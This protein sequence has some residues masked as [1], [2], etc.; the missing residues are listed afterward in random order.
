MRGASSVN[1][2]DV[3]TPAQVHANPVRTRQVRDRALYC[4]IE[5][6]QPE[7]KAKVELQFVSSHLGNLSLDSPERGPSFAQRLYASALSSRSSTL[8]PSTIPV[9]PPT[10]H[11]SSALPSDPC[12]VSSRKVLPSAS[13]SDASPEV[14]QYSNPSGLYHRSIATHG[15]LPRGSPSAEAGATRHLPPLPKSGNLNSLSVTSLSYLA[16]SLES[17]SSQNSTLQPE[18]QSPRSVLHSLQTLSKTARS[19]STSAVDTRKVSGILGVTVEAHQDLH[20]TISSPSPWEQQSITSS[21]PPPPFSGHERLSSSFDE[22]HSRRPLPGVNHEEIPLYSLVD[23]QIPPPAFDDLQPGTRA[24][25]VHPGESPMMQSETLSHETIEVSSSLPP[26]LQFPPPFSHRSTAY[27]PGKVLA[28]RMLDKASYRVDTGKGV[29]RDTKISLSSITT[30][31]PLDLP[32]IIDFQ[33]PNQPPSL[34]P[35]VSPSSTAHDENA[36]S[37]MTPLLPSDSRPPSV[38]SSHSSD[39]QPTKTSHDHCAIHKK[40]SFPPPVN[41]HTKPTA[42]QRSGHPS[43]PPPALQRYVPTFFDEYPLTYP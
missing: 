33:R 26:P 18:V 29:F 35:P 13:L 42:K 2:V 4:T 9:L 21:L 22:L 32:V 5:R 27:A 15:F 36:I 16:N 37:P 1:E 6:R 7:K 40:S 24:S 25:E 41:Y 11:A 12:G 43:L 38:L 28:Y 39:S 19:H 20:G 31:R 3:V 30:R 14:S 17:Q 8:H 10:E 34:A 23:E